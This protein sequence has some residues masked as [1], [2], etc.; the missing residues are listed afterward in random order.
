[1]ATEHGVDMVF[2]VLQA[3]GYERPSLGLGLAAAWLEAA[4]EVDD[5]ELM[6]R[7]AAFMRRDRRAGPMRWPRPGQV[8]GLA[9][10]AVER[11]AGDALRRV[12]PWG[13]A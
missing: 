6:A 7:A 10:R 3:V 13:E 1:M 5:A 11:D 9:P 4:A 8:L 12:A 2:A